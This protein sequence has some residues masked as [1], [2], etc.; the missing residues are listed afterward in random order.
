MLIA[1]SPSLLLIGGLVSATALILYFRKSF[2]L[3]KL[4]LAGFILKVPLS[5]FLLNYSV[6]FSHRVI[7]EAIAG[8][9]YPFASDASYY[10]LR[11]ISYLRYFLGYMKNYTVLIDYERYGDSLYVHLLGFI[12][13]I[14]DYSPLVANLLNCFLG[15]ILAFV[16]YAIAKRLFSLRV[17]KICAVII[18]FLPTLF[19]VSLVSLKDVLFILSFYV[20]AYM[21]VSFCK[22]QTLFNFVSLCVAFEMVHLI[23]D[24]FQLL[25]LFLLS[26]IAF[27]ISS[28]FHL[29]R[30]ALIV[31]IL[32]GG[33]LFV[34]PHGF[35]N[36]ENKVQSNMQGY[37]KSHLAHAYSG[38]IAY[39]YL[40]EKHYRSNKL[41]E[42][43]DFSFSEAAVATVKAVTHFLFEPL[44]WKKYSNSLLLV[45]PQILCW[46]LM[47]PFVFVGFGLS[48]HNRS[49]VFLFTFFSL[50]TVGLALVEGNIGTLVRHRDL[51][52]PLYVI[53][54]VHGFLWVKDRIMLTDPKPWVSQF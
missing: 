2:F 24:H 35:V 9:I 50:I 41:P 47:F 46:I 20:A 34:V 12:F 51:I 52:T 23:R 39:H 38:G 10:P 28:P 1:I 3:L 29:Y 44:I 15:M 22:K 32:V 18:T 17:A 11:A 21:M 16:V 43:I 14:F 45:W 40:D 25:T 19:F 37:F 30:K 31:F 6:A 26:G 49:A 42:S 33:Y 7:N 36:I 54:G 4:F 27:F 53:F 13:Y 8:P 48:F 5:A